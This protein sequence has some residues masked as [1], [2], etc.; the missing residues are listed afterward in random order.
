MNRVSFSR[1]I[2]FSLLMKDIH[3]N[4]IWFLIVNKRQNHFQ[5]AK[6]TSPLSAWK[7]AQCL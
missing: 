4:E 2:L 6:I 5:E 1:T 7:S 3:M